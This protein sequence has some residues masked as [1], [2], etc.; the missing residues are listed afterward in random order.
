MS[1]NGRWLG[2]A[3]T[4]ATAGCG[5]E[6]KYPCASSQSSAMSAVSC[7]SVSTP[8]AVTRSPSA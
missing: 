5:G 6:K 3:L 7:S 2:L 4:L 1:G 8:S